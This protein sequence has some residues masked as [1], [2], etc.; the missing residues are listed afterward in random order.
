M[1]SNFLWREDGDGL[2]GFLGELKDKATRQDTWELGTQDPKRWRQ[3]GQ[4][5]LRSH[6]C[7]HFQSTQ[8]LLW[9]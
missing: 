3:G 1:K 9:H 2:L 6:L 7:N 4:N 5:I 8:A